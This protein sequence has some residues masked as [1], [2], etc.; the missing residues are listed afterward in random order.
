MS[1]EI[2]RKTTL[3]CPSLHDLP[4][5]PPGKT[6]WPW[7]EASLHLPEIRPHGFPWPRISIVTPSYNQGEFIEEAIRS[8]LL[9]GYPNLEYIIIDG[10][11][12]DDTV[13]IIRKYEPWL[14]Y[15]VSEKDDGQTFAIQKGM[16]M[17]SGEIVNWLNSDDYLLPNSA[18]ALAIAY[19]SASSSEC[20][21]CGDAI[22]ITE[23]GKIISESRVV[24]A[25]DKVLPDAPPLTGGIQAS[26][27]L[28]KSAWQKVGGINV[29]LNY[30]MDTDLYYRCNQQDVYFVSINQLIAVYRRHGETKTLRGWKESIAYKKRFYYGG[31]KTLDRSTSKIYR[32]RIQR[33]LFACYLKSISFQDSFVDRLSKIVLALKECPGVLFI[34]YQLYRLCRILLRGYVSS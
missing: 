26:W 24:P 13:E 10:E 14:T 27:F 5:P 33:L 22:H 6:G 21:L 16:E 28:S 3:C 12:T 18:Q 30:T 23:N 11:S 34:P 1:S 2:T 32:P 20:V 7:T 9:Q 29:D 25:V 8:V 15:W 19:H 4:L 31:L 17:A